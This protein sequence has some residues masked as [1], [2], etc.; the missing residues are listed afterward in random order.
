MRDMAASYGIDI[1]STLGSMA[2]GIWSGP[3]MGGRQLAVFDSL[4]R[5]GLFRRQGRV[6]PTGSER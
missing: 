2:V 1:K 5:G 4:R 3:V 6:V